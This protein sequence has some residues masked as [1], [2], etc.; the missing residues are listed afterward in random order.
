MSSVYSEVSARYSRDRVLESLQTPAASLPHKLK[1]ILISHNDILVANVY[2]DA[3]TKLY[4]NYLFL[5]ANGEMVTDTTPVSALSA[6]NLSDSLANQAFESLDTTNT[7]GTTSLSTINEVFYTKRTNSSEKILFA[8][9]KDNN[10]VGAVPETLT[11]SITSLLSGTQI[12]FNKQFKF[13]NV[14]SVDIANNNLFVLD[15]GNNTLFKFDA[16]GFVIQDNAITRTSLNDTIHPGRY[17]LKTIGGKG[18]QNRNNKLSNPTSIS[19]FRN[20]IYVLDNGNYSIKVYDLNFNFVDS[21]IDKVIFKRNPISITVSNASNLSNAARIFILCE[22]GEIF[23]L[24]YNF[25]NRRFYTVFSGYTNKFDNSDYYQESTSFKKILSSKTNNN[26]LYVCTNKSIIKLYKS[27]LSRPVSFYDLNN[28]LRFNN[29]IT[30]DNEK[31]NS[32]SVQGVSAKDSLA[33]V[34]SL[35]TGETRF[36]F[37]DDINNTTLLYDSNFYTN[38]YHVNDIYIKRRELVNSVTI[39]KTIEKIFYNHS[40]F[41]E[42]IRK[43]VYS[44]YTNNKVPALSTVETATFSL[45]DS[46]NK[47][48]DFSI[49]VNEPLITD[50]INRPLKKLYQQQVDIFNTLLESYSNTNPPSEV[51]EVLPGRQDTTKSNVIRFDSNTPN[52]TVTAGNSITYKVIRDKIIDPLSFKVKNNF[53]N[54]ETTSA[55]FT[56]HLSIEEKYTFGEGTSSVDINFNTKPFY[57]DKNGV[58]DKTKKFTT[59]ITSPTGAILDQ[60]S[61]ERKSIINPIT[62]ITNIS[63]STIDPFPTITE[64]SY[65]T[66]AV[67]RKNDNNTFTNSASVNIYTDPILNITNSDYNNISFSNTYGGSI[68][69]FVSVPGAAG[70]TQLSATSLSGSTIHFPSNVSAVFFDISAYEDTV[71]QPTGSLKIKINNPSEGHTIEGIGNAREQVVHFKENPVPIS[72]PINNHSSYSN[73]YVND[74][75]LW[76]LLENNSTYIAC[77]DHRALDVTFYMSANLSAYSTV[78][79]TA[80]IYFDTGGVSAIS[81]GSSVIIQVPSTGAIVGKGGNGGRSVLYLSGED[82][83]PNATTNTVSTTEN[84]L[85]ENSTSYTCN[86]VNYNLGACGM[87]GGPAISLSGFTFARIEN[88]GGIYGGAGGGGAGFLPVTASSMPESELSSLSASGAG[89]G[90]YGIVPNNA[91]L[92]GVNGDLFPNP[93]NTPIGGYA[94]NENFPTNNPDYVSSCGISGGYFSAGPIASNIWPQTSGAWGGALGEPGYGNDQ[95]YCASGIQGWLDTG[96]TSYTNISSFVLRRGGGDAGLAVQLHGTEWTTRPTDLASGI[97]C[98]SDI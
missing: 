16:S 66:F 12:E 89:G 24:S 13:S 82:F 21:Y 22:R 37:V 32:F 61:F 67:I 69:D 10:Y 54:E 96:E 56:P 47:T 6:I 55:D 98:G 70:S 62:E 74:V 78:L 41:F 94:A 18:K 51:S 91:G 86:N 30:P 63:L 73:N 7:T 77:R 36:S 75:N 49:G 95:P 59:L 80:A 65:Y 2:N 3:I 19:V 46:F 87:Q 29:N 14:V 27:N 5:I 53:T 9:G 57:S 52:A 11:G 25:T 38:F 34:T 92:A 64:G 90:G 42:S 43:K 85:Y 83:D 28:K 35:S 97:F 31:I 20:N 72:I 58:G 39:N 44:Y 48:L 81:P 1:D 50:V 26:I 45:P 23:T 15:K 40:S 93:S 8:Y 68:N 17:L 71:A 60:T 88:Y 79:S 84:L 76:S 33:I 4:N